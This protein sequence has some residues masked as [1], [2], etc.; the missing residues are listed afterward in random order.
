[1]LVRDLPGVSVGSIEV[2]VENNM[3]TVRAERPRT[4]PDGIE[5]VV[6]ERPAGVFTRQ[7]FLGEGFDTGHVEAEHRY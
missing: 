6:A 1:M 5:P 3:V 4:V 7:L 2:T